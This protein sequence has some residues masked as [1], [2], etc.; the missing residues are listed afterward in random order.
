VTLGIGAPASLLVHTGQTVV[1]M[2]TNMPTFPQPPDN[3]PVYQWFQNDTPIDSAT[4]SSYTIN[5]A[6]MADA[7]TY[8]A[9]VNGRSGTVQSAPL[10]LGVYFQYST[11]SNGGSLAYSISKFSFQYQQLPCSPKQ[12]DYYYN[13]PYLFYGSN[14]TS[15]SGPFT[16]SSN[17]LLDLS[18][19]T[20]VNGSTLDTGIVLKVNALPS[21][22]VG[23]SDD[24][25]AACAND[26]SLSMFTAT[27]DASK[28]YRFTVLY[29][30]GTLGSLTNI[31]FSWFYHN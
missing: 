5:S 27:L 21:T 24:A 1:I 28:T 10:D 7:A 13:I 18:T 26:S 2:L 23:C 12:F 15:Q 25:G 19:C 11:N 30:T 31:T 3:G 17:G 9:F 20:N 29:R 14:V 6:S 22:T 4:N 16:N 8:F